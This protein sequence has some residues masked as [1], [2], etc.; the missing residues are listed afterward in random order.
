MFAVDQVQ[1]KVICC[2]KKASGKA[3]TLAGATPRSPAFY[4]PSFIFVVSYGL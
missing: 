1:S 2:E 4:P 3:L